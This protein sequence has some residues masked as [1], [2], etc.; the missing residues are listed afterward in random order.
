MTHFEER[1]KYHL[2]GHLNENVPHRLRCLDTWS[3][4]FGGIW[5]G[6]KFKGLA[7][8]NML[9]GVG[10]GISKPL[11]SSSLLSLIHACGP[12]YELSVSSS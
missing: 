9:L 4:V 8:G 5:V 11:T 1:C 2:C 12:R 3:P 7:R 10:L 6:L